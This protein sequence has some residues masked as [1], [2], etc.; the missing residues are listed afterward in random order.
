LTK[1]AHDE[2]L[3]AIQSLS[4]QQREVITLYYISEYTYR[5]ISA[6]LCI[7]TST[8][9][10]RLYHARKHLEENLLLIDDAL[11]E[12]RP[13]SN[14]SFKEKIM[15]FQV[16]TKS[17]PA[18]QVLS[19]ERHASMKDLQANLD[20][21]IKAL[22][23]YAQSES[24]HGQSQDVEIDGLPFA[25]YHKRDLAEELF[26][27]ICLPV[28]GGIES[29]KEIAAKALPS[30]QVAFTSTNLRQSIFPG[31]LKAYQAI[32]EWFRLTDHKSAGPP[33]EI[34]LNYDHS[35]FSAAANWDDPCLE[36]IW[37]YH[38]SK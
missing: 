13:S 26:V 4:N 11:S 35:I 9:K 33:R 15:S 25:I 8:V 22:I 3:K 16:Q 20:G 17:I 30:E 38:C 7:P 29:T 28:K 23:V 6:F 21:G 1:E 27:E 19:I 24:K 34:Y 10:M 18:Q 2:V 36:I 32:E 14:D 31:I 37:P 12:K 5:E